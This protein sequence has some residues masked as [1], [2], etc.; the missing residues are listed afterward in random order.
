VQ[1]FFKEEIKSH[2]W[3]TAPLRREAV[4]RRHA[5]LKEHGSDFLVQVADLLFSSRVL[6]EKNFAVFL[7]EKLTDKFGDKEFRILESWLRE[8]AVGLTMMR[9][10]TTLSDR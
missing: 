3:Y 7:L 10:S 4:R 8:L 1:W 5:I 6:E 2:G 9:S